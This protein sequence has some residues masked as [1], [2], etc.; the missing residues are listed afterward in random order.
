MTERIT[1][2]VQE[3]AARLGCSEGHLYRLIERDE[4]PG[5]YQLGHKHL[6]HKPTFL[7]W[8]ADQVAS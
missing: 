2:T 7:A 3:L 5:A 6:I 4:L 1:F 8:E